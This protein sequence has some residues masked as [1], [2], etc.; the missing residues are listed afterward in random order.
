VFDFFTRNYNVTCGF[1]GSPSTP[2][3]LTQVYGWAQ[4]ANCS[5]PLVSTP[6]YS[7]AIV[8]FCSLQYNYLLK[9]KPADIFNPYTQLIHETLKSNAYAFSIDDKATFK[10]VPSMR[11]GTSPGL[12]IT[13]GGPE[14]LVNGKQAPLPNPDTFEKYCH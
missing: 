7:T 8:D 2:T 1:S 6:G 11:I 5:F 12:I 3:M 10:S 4:F 13:L 9:K 14:G